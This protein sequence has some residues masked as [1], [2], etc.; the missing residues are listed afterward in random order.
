MRL[1][2]KNEQQVRFDLFP[3]FLRPGAVFAKGISYRNHLDQL[4]R[5][6]GCFRDFRVKGFKIRAIGVICGGSFFKHESLALHYASISSPAQLNC[7]DLF[8]RFLRPGAVFAKGISYRNHLDQLFRFLG[9]F[10]DFRVKGFKIR[11][12]GVIC[13]GSTLFVPLVLRFLRSVRSV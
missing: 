7:F 1:S 12:I 10:R 8:P 6:F 2:G 9:C 3:R 4:F 5:F 13:G 11:A